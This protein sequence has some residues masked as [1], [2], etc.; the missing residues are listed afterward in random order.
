MYLKERRPRHRIEE[1]RSGLVLCGR[2]EASSDGGQ[3]WRARSR[4]EGRMSGSDCPGERHDTATCVPWAFLDWW[5][6]CRPGTQSQGPHA[7]G[8]RI[9]LSGMSP[10]LSINKRILDLR[11]RRNKFW[12]GTPR[13]VWH[14]LGVRVLW[15]VLKSLLKKVWH[16][17]PVWPEEGRDQASS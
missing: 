17:V 3:V 9:Y 11:R 1:S 7:R 2:Q 14:Q 8:S 13:S 15:E 5:R 10:L 6:S 12:K 4:D 16:L